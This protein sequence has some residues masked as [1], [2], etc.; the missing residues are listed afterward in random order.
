MSAITPAGTTDSYKRALRDSVKIVRTPT[1]G[2]ASTA[3]DVHA[4]IRS[5]APA[6]IVG[7]IQQ[8]DQ[9]V[10]VLKLDLEEQSFPVPPAAGDRVFGGESGRPLTVKFC[11]PNTV[12][13][14][15]ETIVYVLQCRG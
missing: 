1:S 11:D 10:K 15:D 14:D 9:E 6:E 2:D 12:R 13:V 7:T 5:Y 3:T 8:G 4:R